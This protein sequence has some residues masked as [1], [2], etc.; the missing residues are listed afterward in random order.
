MATAKCEKV[1]THMDC[2]I[3]RRLL[4]INRVFNDCTT[5]LLFRDINF[6]AYEIPMTF[7]E[8]DVQSVV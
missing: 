2:W 3:L 4:L 1:M 7:N 6:S 8:R 5:P